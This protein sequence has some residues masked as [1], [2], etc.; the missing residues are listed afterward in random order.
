MVY[1]SRT[2][3]NN[4]DCRSPLIFSTSPVPFTTVKNRDMDHIEQLRDAILNAKPPYCAGTLSLPPKELLLFYGKEDPKTHGRID[5]NDVND[6]QLQHL[7]ETCDKATFGLNQADVLDESYRKA[8][9]LDSECFCT[10]LDLE[11]SEVMDIL[12]Y[13]LLEGHDS[14]KSII[15]E[16]YKLNVYDK[17]SFFKP[18]KDTPRSTAMFGSLVIVYPTPHEGGALILRHKGKEWTFDSAKEIGNTK[19]IGY[20]TFFSDVEHEVTLVK[21]GFRVTVTYNLYYA[22]EMKPVIPK[23]A[24]VLPMNECAVKSALRAL[25]EDKTF[26]P[27]GIHLGF[28]LSHEYPIEVKADDMNTLDFITQNLKGS[29]ALLMQACKDLNLDARLYVLYTAER[30][31]GGTKYEMLVPRVPDDLDGDYTLDENEDF[32]D[33]LYKLEK[34]VKLIK[35][36]KHDDDVDFHVTWVTEKTSFDQQIA[37]WMAYGNEY[38]M[39][40]TYGQFC[41]I[42][43]VGPAR[44]RDTGV[45]MEETLSTL[46]GGGSK[47]V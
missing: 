23:G 36:G 15:V 25:V 18:H 8:R 2:K 22:D 12:R 46:R 1:N 3:Y 10:K 47:D 14:N 6:E 40:H 21:S 32:V 26:Y 11:Q 38:Y 20:I 35:K 17:D 7:S 31:P 39:D 19:N 41:L 9:K 37:S 42:V 16:L 13:N 33:L 24:P 34:S 29:D 28:G 4:K 43:T 5:F 44:L 45:P 30:P 27:R